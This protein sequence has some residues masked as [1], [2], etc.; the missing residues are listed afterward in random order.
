MGP[1]VVRRQEHA[2]G[3]WAVVAC[4]EM[5]PQLE[6]LRIF[7]ADALDLSDVQWPVSLH[8]LYLHGVTL[9]G[10]TL[11]S[12]VGLSIVQAELTGVELSSG[13]WLEV[14]DRITQS[15]E[16]LRLRIRSCGY[17]PRWQASA[18]EDDRPP[19]LGLY[20]RDLG[21]SPDVSHCGW[22]RFSRRSPEIHSGKGWDRT[23]KRSWPLSGLDWL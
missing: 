18:G 3:R 10:E 16:L 17:S 11:V 22:V 7:A 23:W 6:T 4:I 1:S 14:R 19:A 20:F 13:T 9:S 12:I 5:A 21:R 15:R 2:P 8:T